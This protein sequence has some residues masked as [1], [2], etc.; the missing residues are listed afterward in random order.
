MSDLQKN[1][2]K[3]E[4]YLARFRNDGVSNYIDGKAVPAQ[5]G[6]T[7]EVISPVDLKPLAS[8]ARSGEADVDQAVAAAKEA[9]PAWAAMDG[10]KRKA[11]LH[12]IADAIVERAECC[13]HRT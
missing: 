13:I 2:E 6:Q 12:A 4:T 3:S 10:S 11:V 7:F 9:F 1:I 8:A 5:D